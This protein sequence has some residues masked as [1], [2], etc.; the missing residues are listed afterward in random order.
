MTEIWRSTIAA[1]CEA[2]EI[3]FALRDLI[4]GSLG[5]PTCVSLEL[6]PWLVYEAAAPI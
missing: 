2:R 6:N 5:C 1:V 3:Q 4:Q